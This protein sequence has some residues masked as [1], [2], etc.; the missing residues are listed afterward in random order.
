M[1]N[2]YATHDIVGLELSELRSDDWHHNA[3]HTARHI[4]AAERERIYRRE[5]RSIRRAA[6]K[7]R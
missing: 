5:L 1:F 3:R 7:K 6:R 2:T 4:T